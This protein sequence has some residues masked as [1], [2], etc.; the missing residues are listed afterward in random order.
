MAA[1]TAIR[2]G[3]E[4]AKIVNISGISSIKTEDFNLSDHIPKEE[5]VEEDD[6]F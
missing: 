2:L 3:I 4:K 6:D 1:K 5:K